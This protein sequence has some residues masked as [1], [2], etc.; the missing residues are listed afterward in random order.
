M[1]SGLGVGPRKG[2]IEDLMSKVINI[3]TK[4]FNFVFPVSD[5]ARVWRLTKKANSPI[6][7]R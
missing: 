2:R 3:L 4:K 7:I 5:I 6:L 1:L